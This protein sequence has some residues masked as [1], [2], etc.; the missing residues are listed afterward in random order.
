MLSRVKTTYL[1]LKVFITWKSRFNAI[2]NILFRLFIYQP[3]TSRIEGQ[4]H[5][6]DPA[7]QTN[8]VPQL[9]KVVKP[10]LLH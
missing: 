2:I 9:T 4:L 8:P 7:S 10:L 6:F 3:K 5:E 1:S